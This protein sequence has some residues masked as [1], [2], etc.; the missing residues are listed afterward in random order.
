[1][2]KD[3]D[4]LS[5]K[6]LRVLDKNDR[7]GIEGM[8]ALLTS[9]RRDQSGAW[10]EGLGLTANQAAVLVASV[11]STGVALVRRPPDGPEVTLWRFERG[12]KVA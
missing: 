10:T 9:G 8:C 3:D 4:L 1:M 11:R 5:H 7:L 2:A 6:A 12:R